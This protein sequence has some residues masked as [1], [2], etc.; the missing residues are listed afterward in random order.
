[1]L[2]FAFSLSLALSTQLSFVIDLLK[3][4]Y[5][6]FVLNVWLVF[7]FFIIK[8]KNTLTIFRCDIIVGNKISRGILYLIMKLTR[9]IDFRM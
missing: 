3:P 6:S 8:K 5:T 1:M 9:R 4:Y 2:D 7:V